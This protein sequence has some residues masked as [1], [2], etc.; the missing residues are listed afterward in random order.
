MNNTDIFENREYITKYDDTINE[1]LGKNPY[2][3][4]LHELLEQGYINIDKDAGPTS[5]QVADHLK[6]LLGNSKTGHSGTLDPQVTGVLL[7][8][9]GG[10]TRLMEYM[11]K[12][13]KEY[14]C[15]AFFHK[16][17]TKEQIDEVL[18]KFTGEIM[19]MPPV[20]SAVRRELRPRTIY[21]NKLLD[22]GEDNQHVLFRVACQ[23][24][25]YIRKL[26]TDMGETLDINC[27]MKEL[28]RSKAGPIREEDNIIGLDHL[29][30]LW[31]LYNE[32]AFSSPDKKK[33]R[34]EL[35]KY[36]RPQEELLKEF[37]SVILR[38]AAVN[39]IAHGYKLATP[40][41][42]RAEV[43][44]EVGEEIAMFSEKGELIAMGESLMTTDEMLSHEKG[45]AVK[46]KK[47]FVE[48]NYYP[49]FT[50]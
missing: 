8:G 4:S 47:V 35:R 41:V 34:D 31:T 1:S 30:N 32:A 39:P 49:K 43:G 18:E 19:Q 21:S 42:M 14:V 36:I 40:G 16:P 17:V 2:D 45:F 33:L 20:V 11:L 46:P 29:R 13:N 9:L 23:H 50:K 3:R 44:I 26:C 27:Q 15:L 5:H 22:I 6:K 37:K 7:C 28:R 38:V 12:S 25:T 24:G 10:A 48:S